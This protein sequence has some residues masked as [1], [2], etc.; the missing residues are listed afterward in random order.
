M[1]GI[2]GCIGQGIIKADLG[3]FSTLAFLNQQRGMHSTGVARVFSPKNRAV[4]IKKDTIPA[5]YFLAQKE[6]HPITNDISPVAIMGHNRFATVGNH[7][8]IR[9]AHPFENDRYVGFHN[10]TLIEEKYRGH[11][12]FIT[13]S[14]ALYDDFTT[15][16]MNEVLPTLSKD[17]AFALA[18]Y[19][20]E[21]HRVGFVRNG[22]RPLAFANH[23][24]RN[25]IYYSSDR[26]DLE[27]ALDRHG[28]D[29]KVWDLRQWTNAT[30]DPRDLAFGKLDPETK[31]RDSHWFLSKLEPKPIEPKRNIAEDDWNAYNVYP[32]RITQQNSSFSNTNGKECYCCDKP[33]EWAAAGTSREN[34]PTWVGGA[35]K[36]L[37]CYE[38]RDAIEDGFGIDLK[39]DKDADQYVYPKAQS[40]V[41]D[42]P[43]LVVVH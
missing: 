22:K 6:N 7:G 40:R 25:V 39:T 27:Y 19:D 4:E 5:M 38:C 42:K 26:L 15:N 35:V 32:R 33:L 16:D 18:Y 1:C 20:K 37:V 41:E 13:D 31:T 2:Y 17:S 11:K 36:A 9:G 14:E 21:L 23:S 29:A 10:G 28:I 3:V 43:E 24:T 12:D 34:N 30:V 8:D